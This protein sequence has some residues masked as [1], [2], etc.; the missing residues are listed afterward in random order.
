[1][2]II[3][4]GSSSSGNATCVEADGKTFLI[5]AGLSAKMIRERLSEYSI[6]PDQLDAVFVTHEHTDHIQGLKGLLRKHDIPIYCTRYTAQAIEN[7]LKIEPDFFIFSPGETFRFGN[8]KVEGVSVFHDA[9]DPVGFVFKTDNCKMSFVSDIGYVTSLVKKKLEGTNVLIIESNHDPK[10]LMAD[11]KRPMHVKQRIRGRQGH[12]SNEN[13]C[14]LV[15]E[16][17]HDDLSD[18][19]LFHLSKD[20]NC[21]EIALNLMENTVKSLGK[22][23]INVHMTYPHK[24]SEIVFRGLSDDINSREDDNRYNQLEMSMVL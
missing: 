13:A 24:S 9:Q 16:I 20:C 23:E 14:E 18:I 10:M 1:M 12:L 7:I 22:N 4:L 3:V 15:R 8:F 17:M 2:K 21:R 11:H 19:V 6:L 5:D